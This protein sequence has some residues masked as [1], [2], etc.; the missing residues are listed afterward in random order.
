MAKPIAYL[1]ADREGNILWSESCVC[2]DPVYPVDEN[3]V[4]D[5]GHPTISLPLYVHTNRANAQLRADLVKKD[6]EIARL[7][8]TV[9]ALAEYGRN[10]PILGKENRWGVNSCRYASAEEVIQIAKEEAALKARA[11]VKGG[12]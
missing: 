12:E 5:R 11:A 4:D 1:R 3:D 6:E 7:R 10:I 2:Q 9:D 8:D